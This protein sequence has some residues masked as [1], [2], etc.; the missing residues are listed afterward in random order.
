MSDTKSRK[1]A[2]V[3]GGNQG[4]G[5]A[6]VRGLCR[7]VGETG[8]VYLGA[9]NDERGRAA[10]DLL[11]GEGLRPEL[12]AIDVGDDGSVRAAADTLGALHGGID[13]VISNAAQRISKDVPSADQVAAFVN[14]N[15]HG[16]RRMIRAFVPLLRD[17][18]RFVVVASSFGSLRNL[19]GRLHAKFHGRALTLDAVEQAMDEYVE[20][21][22]SGGAVAAGWPD[23][24]NIPSK[25]GQ[26]AA[27]RVLAREGEAEFRRRGIL[28]NTACP[29][30]VDTDAS[31]PWFDDMSKA[32]S[33]DEAA[34]DLIW[35]AT[36]PPAT[37]E[38]YGELIR[39]RRP[40]PWQ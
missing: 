9:R 1:I 3:T 5:L 26:V 33:P 27:V 30:L 38:P 35:L 13:V 23:W 40:L 28:I 18:A 8:T 21:V 12:M 19:D 16:T 39:N 29:G 15:N 11:R 37:V 24:I 25:I 2:L 32:A 22:R 31:R 36:L 20:A 6:L 10:C 34:R 4:L 14:T 7:A 17:N